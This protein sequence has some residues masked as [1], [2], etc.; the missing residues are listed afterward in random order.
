MVF[1]KTGFFHNSSV[2][3]GRYNL[4]HVLTK[5]RNL[6]LYY[7]SLILKFVKVNLL[8]AHERIMFISYNN[9]TA[10]T[11]LTAHFY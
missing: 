4:L 6:S 8:I 11:Y 9:V 1:C 10:V 3:G 2:P 5:W 7:M